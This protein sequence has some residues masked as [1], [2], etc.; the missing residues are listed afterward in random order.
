MYICLE[1]IDG[2]GKTTISRMLSD[3]LKQSGYNVLLVKE[4]YTTY[5]NNV[6]G[7]VEAIDSE[8]KEQI[9]LCLYAADRLI[10]LEQIEQYKGIII[11]DRSKYSSFAHQDYLGYNYEVNGYMKT[12]DIIIFLDVSSEIAFERM[13]KRNDGRDKSKDKKY[14]HKIRMNYR[15]RVKEVA[16]EDF[17]KWI[18]IDASRNLEEVFKD[19]KKIVGKICYD[20][21]DNR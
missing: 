6:I 12:P 14:L 11:S 9:L 7:I 20:K 8:Y 15:G 19:V 4:P 21:Q 17:V 2:S 18:E 13:L 3:S 1:G 10:L 16:E 5:I